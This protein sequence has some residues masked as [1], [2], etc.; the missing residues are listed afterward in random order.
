MDAGLRTTHYFFVRGIKLKHIHHLPTLTTVTLCAI[1][2]IFRTLLYSDMAP[3]F[4]SNASHK[5]MPLD[6]HLTGI[7]EIITTTEVFW[8]SSNE[9]PVP[10]SRASLTLV[11]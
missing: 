8:I 7:P 11:M 10:R 3:R 5:C 6:L 1:L 9:E 4:G 2:D